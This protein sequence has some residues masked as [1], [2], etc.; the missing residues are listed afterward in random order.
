MSKEQVS[1]R[2]PESVLREIERVEEERG[3][4]NRTEACREVL[5][6]GIDAE[7]GHSAGEQLGQQATSVAV[8]GSVVALIAAGLGAPWA[9]ALV[10]PFGLATPVLSLIWASVRVLEGRE[11]L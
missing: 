6:K 4:D 5:R 8:V 9:T 10:V 1:L 11:L 2:V 7:D 3:Y